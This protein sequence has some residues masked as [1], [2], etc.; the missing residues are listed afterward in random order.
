MWACLIPVFLIRFK[1]FL[2]TSLLLHVKEGLLMFFFCKLMRIR[3]V[4]FEVPWLLLRRNNCAQILVLLFFLFLLGLPLLHLLHFLPLLSFGNLFCLLFLLDQ[5]F[6]SQVCAFLILPFDIPQKLDYLLKLVSFRYLYRFFFFAIKD[7]VIRLIDNKQV[8]NF[9]VS[10]LTSEMKRR[11]SLIFSNFVRVCVHR[12]QLSYDSN[13]IQFYG[14]QEWSH[15][16]WVINSHKC[17]S[18]VKQSGND[19][20]VFLSSHLYRVKDF[21]FILKISL[22]KAYVFVLVSNGLH[23]S[24]ISF[25]SSDHKNTFPSSLLFRIY[26]CPLLYQVVNTSYVAISRSAPTAFCARYKRHIQVSLANL[27]LWVENILESFFR[28]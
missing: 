25:F 12:Q 5:L 1:A 11:V 21:C 13:F 19:I 14:K 6:L 17:T 18:S 7:L 15:T 3:L 8:Y 24:N 22:V 9:Q 10:V 28:P 26:V 2:W 16:I 27:G 23:Q 20:N 4:V